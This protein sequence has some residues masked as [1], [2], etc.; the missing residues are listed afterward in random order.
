MIEKLKNMTAHNKQVLS[1]IVGAFIVKGGSLI[2]SILLLPA[3]LD[4]FENQTILG[5]W[6]TILSVLNWVNLFDLGLGQG[7]RNQLPAAIESNDRQTMKKYISTTYVLMSAVA[8]IIAGIGLLII[9]QL[10]WNSIFNVSAEIASNQLL[11]LCVQIVF[12]GIILQIVLKIVTSILYAL[13][14]SAVVNVLSLCTNVIVLV[15]L[16]IIPRRSIGENLIT[17]SIVNV[18]AANFPYIVCTLIVFLTIL[19]DVKPNFT[20]FSRKYIKN[21][22]NIGIALLWL[23]IVF[24][25]VS[26][27][28]EF[29]ISN[30]SDPQY[31][32]EYQAYF[33][34]FKTAAMIVSLALTPIWSAVTR[35]Q[36][37]KNYQ[38]IIKVYKIFIAIAAICF[39]GE[40]CVIPL[41]QWIFDIWIGENVI[42][43]N[44]WYAVTFVFSSVIFVLHNVN[45]TIGNGL[46]YFRLQMIWMTVAAVVFIPLS[47][48]LVQFTGSWIGIV[49][50]NVLSMLPYE[51]LA[52]YYT[53]KEIK[54]LSEKCDQKS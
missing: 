36:V 8:I 47:Y 2:I 45:T 43:V 13:Q 31:V 44:N 14:K 52:P 11:S 10:N 48:L 30:F 17:M 21:I 24:M 9:P 19:K 27:A 16:M 3:Y 32:V 42:Y 20:F 49:I 35:A 5:I 12:S 4:F 1:N 29:L 26:S 25:V 6:Y 23:Q 38:W 37:H 33:K 15:M 39:V 53:M 54:K 50:A 40:L 7:L 34:V 28:N 51:I 46:S 22:F 18:I 41:L